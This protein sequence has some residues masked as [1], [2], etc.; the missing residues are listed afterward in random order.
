M[1]S[2]LTLLL[3]LFLASAGAADV[4][5]ELA[6]VRASLDQLQS[7]SITLSSKDYTPNIE[8][9]ILE[10]R[11]QLK[12]QRPHLFDLVSEANLQGQELKARTV[13]DGEW[14][15]V[16]T[17]K[18]KDG[19]F[20]QRSI[21][22]VLAKLAPDHRRFDTGYY[23]QGIGLA[24]GLD[25][26]ETFQEILEI[27]E[28]EAADSQGGQAVYK[29]KMS[30]QRLKN[31][32]AQRQQGHLYESFFEDRAELGTITLFIDPATSLPMG[33]VANEPMVGITSKLEISNL[34]QDPDFADGVFRYTPPDLWAVF[35]HTEVVLQSRDMTKA[36]KEDMEL[37]AA[38]E[39]Y[40]PYKME[41]PQELVSA[42]EEKQFEKAI[43]ILN[44]SPSLWQSQDT[45]GQ[46]PV[47]FFTAAGDLRGLV[48]SQKYRAD[49]N[50]LGFMR[51]TPL[52]LAVELESTL[53]EEIIG[54]LL[55]SNAY[56]LAR[57]HFGNTPLHLAPNDEVAEML[58]KAGSN[59]DLLNVYGKTPAQCLAETKQEN[60]P[61]GLSWGLQAL[62]EEEREEVKKHRPFFEAIEKGDSQAL[63]GFL[64]Q[65]Y[66]ANKALK[67]LYFEQVVEDTTPLDYAAFSN[68][69]SLKT[70]V[71]HFKSQASAD[72]IKRDLGL[73]LGSSK[74]EATARYL[75]EQ[76]AD[77]TVELEREPSLL[78]LPLPEDVLRVLLDTDIDLELKNE[79]GH[80]ALASLFQRLE[81]D[82]QEL[83]R[84]ELFLDEGA[85]VNVPYTLHPEFSGATILHRFVAEGN[86]EG[87]KLVL[88]RGADVNA[89][90]DEGWTALHVAAMEGSLEIAKFL[91]EK[92]AKLDT[93]ADLD[94]TPLHTASFLQKESIV[95][96]LLEKGASPNSKDEAGNTPLH[97]AAYMADKAIMDALQAAGA[98]PRAQN[99]DGERPGEI[100]QQ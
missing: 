18:F 100:P 52:H 34:E 49:L 87:A 6:Q 7:Y 4:A 16:D 29:G 65:G 15:W 81:H 89:R 86:L 28:F 71:T 53:R 50:A 82:P 14:Q 41:M 98:D 42:F 67:V 47:H 61:V 1:T 27:Y 2:R 39:Q 78:F 17:S 73:A 25:Y 40:F 58:L 5:E 13:F 59:P 24:D 83:E 77:A 54:F 57:D 74:N 64:E 94:W 56:P 35:D 9:P 26:V 66:R 36:M 72:V 88:A 60:E 33:Y 32:F 95:H 30:Q 31:H 99:K 84:M 76:G 48:L 97:L 22:K 44:E 63:N 23:F 80:T 38:L 10:A 79:Q 51:A 68:L 21:I 69:D 11:S 85:D 70:L 46:R 92:G 37:H 93:P 90:T 19:E 62:S 55:E 3:L 12:V 96:Y 75:L 20:Q 91:V 8:D 43:S 45:L